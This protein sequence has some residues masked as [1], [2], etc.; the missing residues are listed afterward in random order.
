MAGSKKHLVAIPASSYPLILHQLG[1]KD[2]VASSE[3][4]GGGGGG[5][6]NYDFF[7]FLVADIARCAV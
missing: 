3:G 5:G 1:K 7:L 4:R 6:L 2:L